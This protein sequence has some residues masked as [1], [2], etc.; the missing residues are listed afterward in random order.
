MCTHVR[1]YLLFKEYFRVHLG[2]L[3]T[4]ECRSPYVDY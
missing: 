2:Q 3:P 1:I 4:A